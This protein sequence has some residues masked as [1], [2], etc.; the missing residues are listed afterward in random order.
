MRAVLED[1]GSKNGTTV[2]EEAVRAERE[3]RDG[4]R[5]TFG[6]VDALYC[7]SEAGPPT[8]TVGDWSRAR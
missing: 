2:G 7:A 8:V 4:D 6:Q 5:I 1:V 3:L